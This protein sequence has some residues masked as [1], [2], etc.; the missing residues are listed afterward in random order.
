[1]YLCL[2]K[3][4]LMSVDAEVLNM[5][6]QPLLFLPFAISFSLN[7]EIRSYREW[8]YRWPATLSRPIADSQP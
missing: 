4:L 6:A 2:T 7:S 1:M 5:P 8:K 3:G